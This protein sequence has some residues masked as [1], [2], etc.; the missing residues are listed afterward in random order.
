MVGVCDGSQQ[1]RNNAESFISKSRRIGD[2][3]NEE[4]KIPQ[5]DLEEDA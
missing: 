1:S 2:G 3:T 5:E 4:E